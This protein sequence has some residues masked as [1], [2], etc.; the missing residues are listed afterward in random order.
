MSRVKNIFI[1]FVCFPLLGLQAQDYSI[2]LLPF[3]T[4]K[5][6]E[7]SPIYYK[8][9]IAFCSNR[10]SS[11]F[12][13]FIDEKQKLPLL[14][15]YKVEEFRK[16][17]WGDVQLFHKDLK[18]PFNEGPATF[19]ARGSE[20]YFTR[21]INA[22]LKLKNSISRKNNLGIFYSKYQR[23][24]K[25]W[26]NPVPFKYSDFNFNNAHPSLSEDGNSL[27]FVSDMPGGYGGTDIYVS[28]RENG[29]WNK[30][31]NLGPEINTPGNEC[32]PFIHSS[33]RLYFSS[34]K[35]GSIGRLDI[36][37]SEQINNKWHKPIPM[38]APIN[39]RY[40]DFALIIDAFMKKGYFSSDR[41][42]SSDD[43][44]MF[45][46]LYPMF[47]N[48]QKQKENDYCYIFYEEG[49]E[50]PDST[51]FDYEWKFSDGEKKVGVEV[52]HCF[53]N[54][55]NFTVELNVIDKLTG[56]ILYTQAS[57]QLSIEDIKQVYINAPDTVLV[58]EEVTMDGRKTN[59]TDFKIYKYYWDFGD[60]RKTRGVEVKHI[61]TNKGNYIIQLGVVS[62]K[63]KKGNLQK[64]GVY[65]SIVV[66]GST[67]S[68]NKRNVN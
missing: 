65:K 59:I 30:P 53:N 34:N 56:D 61:Y 27:F 19:N 57:Y 45:A 15:I 67:K 14:D 3:N 5:Y 48:T 64:R 28:K 24:Y 10:K 32:F 35:H 42:I 58:G 49:T 52:E 43:I 33:G 38:E 12:L 6:D 40:N 63:D 50:N 51:M 55:G 9:D 36:F 26:S 54:T 21:N 31:Q 22:S 44:Y 16:N 4:D 13:S 37:Y 41:Q 46:P 62:K 20:I 17:R 7:F 66:V 8:G 18:T 23:R 11:I 29:V 68:K 2:S 39:S 25:G 60:G 1:F 47:E